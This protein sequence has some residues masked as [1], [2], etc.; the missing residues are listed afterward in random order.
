MF[1]VILWNIRIKQNTHIFHLNALL[2]YN[3]FFKTTNIFFFEVSTV[4]DSQQLSLNK[5]I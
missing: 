3:I 2:F 1:R 5:A 4:A